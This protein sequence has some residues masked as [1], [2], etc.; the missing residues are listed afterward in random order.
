M[1]TGC[2]PSCQAWRSSV[3]INHVADSALRVEIPHWVIGPHAHWSTSLCKTSIVIALDGFRDENAKS[4]VGEVGKRF[5]LAPDVVGCSRKSAR[6][7]PSGMS[8]RVRLL[9]VLAGDTHA[10]TSLFV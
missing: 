1:K 9:A 10:P 3:R 8:L 2:R 7:D 6:R 5:F 4:A